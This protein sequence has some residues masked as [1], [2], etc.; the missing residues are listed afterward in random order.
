MIQDFEEKYEFR[1]I[2]STRS[3]VAGF[4]MPEPGTITKLK[5]Y[6]PTGGSALADFDFTF[7]KNGITQTLPGDDFL[8]IGNGVLQSIK[9]GVGIAVAEGDTVGFDLIAIS[10]PS[11]LFAPIYFIVQFDTGVTYGLELGPEAVADEA[12][13]F[14][15]TGKTFGDV[16]R[17]ND[18]GELYAVIDPD[19]LDNAGG[20]LLLITESTGIQLDPEVVADQAARYALTG[21]T[22]GDLVKQTDTRKLY[23][24]IDPANL[25]NAAGYLLLVT[26]PP[27]QISQSAADQAARF[28]LTG[29][30]YGDLVKQTDTGGVYVVIDPANLGNSAGWLLLITPTT[31]GITTAVDVQTYTSG[32]QNWSK[33]SG[34]KIV[35]VMLWGA[36]GGGAGGAW[37][38]AGAGVQGGIGGGG[39]AF[40]QKTFKA[41]DLSST[42]DVT[43]GAA[44]TH[45]N[46]AT[47]VNTNGTDGTQGGNTSFG[48]TVKL[49]A[50]GGGGGCRGQAATTTR[51]G[52]EGGAASTNTTG[53]RGLTGAAANQPGRMNPTT[54][55]SG[56]YTYPVMGN[57]GG[58]NQAGQGGVQAEYGGASSA[59]GTSL[60]NGSNSIY[61]G[62]SGGGGGCPSSGVTP[63]GGAGGLAGTWDATNGGGGGTAGTGSATVPTSGGNGAG[64]SGGRAG[65]GGGGG[66]STTGT[67]VQAGAGGTGGTPSGGG[68]GGGAKRSFTGSNTAGN[69]GDGGA[70]LAI[71]ITYL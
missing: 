56:N 37:F 23:A 19:E 60:T 49:A 57:S 15:L 64:G 36:G 20:Y 65:S 62:A 9:T 41:G 17:Q 53:I 46:G 2:S 67:N 55:G 22:Y 54:T 42:E 26:E 21:K 44:G 69:G 68:G 32:S 24:V 70:G 71:V 3:D 6:S 11:T 58:G 35:E 61:G 12:A 59:S 51:S 18:T 29:L 45:G 7:T 38:D 52:A 27:N 48:T 31:A 63:N 34:A 33:P 28:A 47:A 39:G 16:I 1:S 10:A 50:G 14:A 30:T 5:V 25:G 4:V 40:I 13:R 43:V 66:G 8:R